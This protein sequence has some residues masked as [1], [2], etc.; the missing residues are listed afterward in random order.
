MRIFA[1]EWQTSYLLLLSERLI[2]PTSGLTAPM[3]KPAL[4]TGNFIMC[5]TLW[6]NKV[7]S[8]S[9]AEED[10]EGGKHLGRVLNAT[11]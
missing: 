11:D 7:P 9:D 4:V 10:A 8:L 6:G 2:L 5:G 1:I 3:C